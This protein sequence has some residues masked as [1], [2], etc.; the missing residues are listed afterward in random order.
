MP[1]PNGRDPVSDPAV[2]AAYAHTPDAVARVLEALRPIARDRG[3]RLIALVGCGGDR[4][5]GKRPQM[6]ALAS[7][8][9]DRLYATS[10]NPRTEDPEHILDQMIA[11][12]ISASE[13]GAS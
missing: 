5:P 4:D 13:G 11:G 10:D 2:F 7:R 12:V 1:G 3:G 9:A 8:G 6:G